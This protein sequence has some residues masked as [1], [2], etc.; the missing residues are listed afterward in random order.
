MRIEINEVNRLLSRNKKI[1]EE[2]QITF[3]NLNTELKKLQ[4]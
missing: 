1:M 3:N 2:M 4:K